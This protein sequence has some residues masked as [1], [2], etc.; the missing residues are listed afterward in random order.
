VVGERE[1]TLAAGEM[2]MPTGAPPDSA[3]RRA[4]DCRSGRWC[5][6]PIVR[7]PDSRSV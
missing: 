7:R 5:R 1:P 3:L 4:T 6:A 2:A